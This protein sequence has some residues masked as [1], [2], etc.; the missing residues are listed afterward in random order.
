[1]TVNH[2]AG[3]IGRRMVKG[4]SKIVCFGTELVNGVKGRSGQSLVGPLLEISH[5]AEELLGVGCVINI[6]DLLLNVGVEFLEAPLG[7][8]SNLEKGV[9][10]TLNHGDG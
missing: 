10:K 2:V 7:A 9:Q 8:V 1:M 5:Q 6:P 3:A 4:E